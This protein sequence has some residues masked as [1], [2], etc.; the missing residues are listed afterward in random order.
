MQRNGPQA[1]CNLR[2]D[3]MRSL[4][5]AWS[6]DD[7]ERLKALVAS[8]ASTVK[9]AGALK[10]TTKSVKVRAR[11]LGTPFPPLRIMRKR[12]TPEKKSKNELPTYIRW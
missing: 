7:E 3:D 11:A 4:T 1:A 9:A 5:R 8:G 6:A 12:W 2:A 10:R